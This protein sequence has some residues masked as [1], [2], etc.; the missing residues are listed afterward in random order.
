M[1]DLA[2]LL[3]ALGLL[4]RAGDLELRGITDDLIVELADLA[5]RGVHAPE[6]MPFTF[7]WT[8][9]APADFAASFARYHWRTRAEFSTSAW[10]LN[11]AVVHRGVVV[12][13][14]GVTTSDFLVTRTGETGSW[15]GLAHQ[16][17][18]LGTV[19]RQVMCAFLFEHLDFAQITSGAFNDNPASLR[20]SDKVGYVP[21]GSVRRERRGAP[22]D[23][24]DLLLTP[25]AFRRGPHMLEVEGL[26]AFRRSIG[27]DTA[28]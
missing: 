5:A 28:D 8:D 22:A 13:V 20:V 4:V 2:T 23:H 6:R 21:N 14:Q 27:L 1:S 11:L 26:E 9:T 16:G 19:M 10:V 7:P 15:L 17:K 25:R 3:P 24:T 18:G 12:G